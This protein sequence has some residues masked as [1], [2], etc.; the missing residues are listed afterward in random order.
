LNKNRLFQ[1]DMSLDEQA[2]NA[3][4]RTLAHAFARAC[5]KGIPK[6][7]SNDVARATDDIQTP[8]QRSAGVR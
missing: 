5:G 3:L 6:D 7:F 2:R 4:C 1:F 8:F